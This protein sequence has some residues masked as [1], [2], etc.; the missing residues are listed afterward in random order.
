MPPAAKTEIDQA[1]E[2]KDLAAK[3]YK[4]G[5]YEKA[6][7]KYFQIINIV[8]ENEA[9]KKSA[10]GKEL[11]S[12]A[13]LN[14]ALCKLTTKDYDTAIDQCERVLDNEPSNWKAAFR[15]ANAMYQKNGE[16]KNSLQGI[17]TVHN[18]AKKAH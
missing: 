7:E 13:R 9:V 10:Q 16:F 14:I 8:R 2:V 17:R 12:Q 15:M 5:N 1:K 3:D 11:D 18:Y 6:C 4:A